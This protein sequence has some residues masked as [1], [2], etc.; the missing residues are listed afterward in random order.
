MYLDELP[1]T[2]LHSSPQFL[3]SP[4][5][6]RDVT[7]RLAWDVLSKSGTH[8]QHQIKMWMENWNLHHLCG[9]GYTQ[10][11][12][13]LSRALSGLAIPGSFSALPKT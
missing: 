12:M 7:L 6:P 1:F 9:T 11:I 3:H 10:V 5:L 4:S 2:T 8:R 13:I